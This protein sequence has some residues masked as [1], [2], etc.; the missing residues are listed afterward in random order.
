MRKF[1]NEES[2]KEDLE[3]LNAEQWQIDLLKLNPDYL[4]WGCFEDYMCNKGSG[5]DSR[6]IVGTWN[7]DEWVLDEYNECVNFYFEIYRKSHT[8]EACDGSQLN[9]QTKQLRDDWYD[10]AGTGRRWCHNI[11]E[12]EIEQL[13][14]SG[15]IKSV[16]NFNGHFSKDRNAWCKWVDGELVECERPP[17]PSPAVVNEWAKNDPMAHDGINHYIC[18]STRAKDLG[19]Y[20]LCESCDGRGVIYDEPSATVGLQLWI[21]HPRK[22]CS[23][24]VY[25]EKIEEHQLEEVFCYLREAAE[26]NSDRFSKINSLVKG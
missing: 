20:G 17:M 7:K 10:L 2:H 8:C 26:R 13:M 6:M 1:L 19:V 24:G 18:Y 14:M 5:W 12:S 15:R 9:P 16:S 21:L 25:I 22:G 11:N 3:D 23:R 4:W